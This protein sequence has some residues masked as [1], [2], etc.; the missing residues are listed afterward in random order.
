MLEG[1]LSLPVPFV[2]ADHLFF[3]DEDPKVAIHAV[4]MF[5]IPQ[6]LAVLDFAFHATAE[7]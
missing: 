3:L 4:E 1:F 7:S 6:L 5:P 2:V